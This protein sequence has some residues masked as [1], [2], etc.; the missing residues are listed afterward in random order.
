MLKYRPDKD[1]VE[2]FLKKEPGWN[3]LGCGQMLY[4][5]QGWE[6]GL[7]CYRYG[8]EWTDPQLGVRQILLKNNMASVPEGWYETYQ[9]SVGEYQDA[10]L[11]EEAGRE[12]YGKYFD[13][14]ERAPIPCPFPCVL[15][16]AG[17]RVSARQP[18]AS[19]VLAG[20]DKA[21]SHKPGGRGRMGIIPEDA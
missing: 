21:S 11:G 6:D 5:D 17:R 20:R 7:Y 15:A 18:A 19:Q 13:L 14:K 10:A 2:L 4:E 8:Y 16:K 12:L 9:I 1:Q 3:L